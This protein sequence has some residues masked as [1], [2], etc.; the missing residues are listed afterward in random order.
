MAKDLLHRRGQALVALAGDLPG[1]AQRADAGHEQALGRVDVAHPDHDALVHQEGLHRRLAPPAALEQV[2]A[3]EGLV[4]R[5]RAQPGQQG[6][7]LAGRLPEQAAEPARVVETQQAAVVQADV[8]VVVG[9]HGGVA[10][11]HAQA[12]GHA[13]VQHGAAQG[14]IEQQ[15]LGAPA[16]TLNRLAGQLGADLLG[17][18][19]AQV[20]AAQDH[21]VHAAAFQ[22]RGQAATGGFYFGKFGH[23]GILASRPRPVRR[24]V[25]A[26]APPVP[27]RSGSRRRWHPA[28]GIAAPGSGAAARG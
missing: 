22:V 23:G 28:C 11:Q 2:V 20:R 4:Q 13:Q 26:A 16:H 18:R 7:G 3:V 19:P 14:G 8:H 25:S 17:D 15:V 9:A 21:A 1:L 10:G 5:L 12:A 24:A 27:S 6:V